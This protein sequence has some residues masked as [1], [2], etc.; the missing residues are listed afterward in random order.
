MTE[1]QNILEQ[2]MTE[3]SKMQSAFLYETEVSK[4]E[5]QWNKIRRHN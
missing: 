2:R 4:M 3:Y 1:W 5:L